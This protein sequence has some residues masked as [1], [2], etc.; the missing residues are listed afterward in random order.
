MEPCLNAAGNRVP[1]WV[2]RLD[3][4]A[5]AEL[6]AAYGKA[7]D[8]S[9]Q[10]K[11]IAFADEKKAIQA[12][13]ALHEDL[14]HQGDV[15]EATREAIPFL[16][17]VVSEARPVLVRGV[18]L[19]LLGRIVESCVHH[20]EREKSFG[21]DRDAWSE[22]WH[23]DR[24]IERVWSGSELFARLLQEDADFRIRTIAAFVL[25]QL[26]T[27]GP[28]LSSVEP[29]GRYASAVSAIVRHLQGAEK[30]DMVRSS[31]VFA[32]GRASRHDL[33]LIDVVR[34]AAAAPAAGRSTRVAAAL[35]VMQI[36]D[37]KH[38]KL[39][40]VDLLIDTMCRSDLELVLTASRPGGGR[41]SSP[42]IP[43]KLRF[44]LCEVLCAWSAGNQKRM[45]RVLPA[46]LAS[47]RMTSAYVASID[48][49]PIF[50]WLWSERRSELVTDTSGKSEYVRPAP[51]RSADLNEMARRVLRGCCDNPSIWEQPIGN[52]A[53]TFLYVGLPDTRAG[54]QKL[55][56]ART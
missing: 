19:R 14:I 48:L 38:A 13:N 49:G 33:S 43:E 20:I 16:I 45:Q 25:G 2:T 28:D 35:A 26:L 51:L 54:L 8:V 34:A 40:E 46:L 31:V 5:W 22:E 21:H 55:L 11:T 18:V 50:R 1:Q 9:E 4:V 3:Q 56:A 39:D 41:G 24:W 42:W 23:P 47:I 36:A 12:Y 6:D 29:R 30:D 52:T 27:R 15:Y 37:G 32:A 10:I 7:G 17:E 44:Y 53:E